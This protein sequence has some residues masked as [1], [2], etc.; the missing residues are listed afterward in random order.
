MKSFIRVGECVAKLQ[1]ANDGLY[2]PGL[3]GWR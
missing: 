1:A 2:R 3:M